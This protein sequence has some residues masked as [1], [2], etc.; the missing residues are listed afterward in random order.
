MIDVHV[1]DIQPHPDQ[2]TN[3]PGWWAT[4]LA[5]SYSGQRRTFWRWYHDPSTSKE[6]PLT[7]DILRRF[8]D[9]VFADLNGFS[10][11]KGSL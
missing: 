7:D 9:A 3:N 10:F 1:L 5:V 8:W 4:R 2:A 11:D 6:K